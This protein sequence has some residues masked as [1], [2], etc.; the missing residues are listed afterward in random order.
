MDRTEEEEREQA[1]IASRKWAKQ[2]VEAINRAT[3]LIAEVTTAVRP[4]IAA[5]K[6]NDEDV[7]R[8]AAEALGKLGDTQAVQPLI[9][10]LRDD[11]EYIRMAAAEALGKLGD[12]QAVPPLSGSQLIWGSTS[13]GKSFFTD[14]FRDILEGSFIYI[15]KDT[16]RLV[17]VEEIQEALSRRVYRLVGP[18]PKPRRKM[19]FYERDTGLTRLVLR[20]E[21]E[22][23]EGVGF[24]SEYLTKTVLPYIE[25]LIQIQKVIG[26][27]VLA[28]RD[29]SESVEQIG[30]RPY[31]SL[32]EA[33]NVMSRYSINGVPIIDEENRLVG[34]LTN[35]D[36]RFATDYSRPISNYM[37]AEGLITAEIGTTL[38]GAKEILH[39]YDIDTLPL[40]DDGGYLTGLFTYEIW[41]E[42]GEDVRILGISQGSVTV[43]LTGGIRDSIELVRDS[44]VPW[45]RAHQRTLAEKELAEKELALKLKR[46]EVAEAK[47]AV[48]RADGAA[49]NEAK[50]TEAEAEKTRAEAEKLRA[51]ALTVHAQ[52]RQMELANHRSELELMGL[53]L[54]MV[55]KIKPDLSEAELLLYAMKLVD[56][57]RVIATSPLELVDAQYFGGEEDGGEIGRA[58]V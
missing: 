51:E 43:D 30:L 17:D 52:A 3:N 58:H 49:E 57:V 32:Q 2:N 11:N 41:G 23:R 42:H 40:V 6:D 10:A 38:E 55:K 34:I 21:Q 20:D 7:R 29:F 56:P 24:S 9:A 25:A 4:L 44:V 27:D 12:T 46:V 28:L 15:P 48:E 18:G 33:Q 19:T 53:A 16:T 13:Q 31:D 47:A 22:G 45:R 54:E 8:T 36:V 5:L 1:I 35:R 50:R 37:V 14:T 39:R 26:K